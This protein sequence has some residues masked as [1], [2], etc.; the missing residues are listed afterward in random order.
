MCSSTLAFSAASANIIIDG[1]TDRQIS[2][3]RDAEYELMGRNYAFKLVVKQGELWVTGTH[4]PDKICEHTGKISHSGQ[5][6]VC[7]PNRVVVRLHKQE[8]PQ[9]DAVL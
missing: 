3:Q 8:G 6:I 7:L 4:C 9:L 5:S 1:R 2:L